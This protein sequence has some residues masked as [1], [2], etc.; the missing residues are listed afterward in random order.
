MTMMK[1]AIMKTTITVILFKIMMIIMIVMMITP[2]I[3]AVILME[4]IIKTMIL[5]TM[6]EERCETTQMRMTV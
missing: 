6:K 5:I 1:I 4:T 3:I 2:T